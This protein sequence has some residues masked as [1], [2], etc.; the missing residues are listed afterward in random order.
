MSKERTLEL[1]LAAIEELKLTTPSRE[2]SIALTHLQESYLWLKH[3][4]DK[5]I[6]K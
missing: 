6:G 2:N 5:I 1:V 3:Q 4:G